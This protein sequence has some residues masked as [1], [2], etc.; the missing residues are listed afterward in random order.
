[1]FYAHRSDRYKFIMCTNGRCGS[2]TIKR[3][4][5]K[6]HG[7]P[8]PSPGDFRSVHNALQYNDPALHISRDEFYSHPYFKFILVRNPWARLVSFYKTLVVVNQTN[9]E[10][11]GRANSFEQLVNQISKDGPKDAHTIPQS[12]GI[13]GLEFDRVI[14]LESIGVDM[15]EICGYCGIDEFE[16][17]KLFSSPLTDHTGDSYSKW[18]GERFVEDGVW[19][20]WREFYTQEI[21]DKVSTIY[22]SD[23]IAFD[24]QWSDVGSEMVS[25]GDHGVEKKR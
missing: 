21:L 8:L 4:F 7:R 10:G 20:H 18:A 3:W 11:M 13:Q 9:S 19:P 1:M 17:E 24:Y 25:G 14:S 6:I 23:L 2:T 22:A 12:E 15:S 16:E 5:L